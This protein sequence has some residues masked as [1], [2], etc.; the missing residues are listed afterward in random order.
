MASNVV[1][2]RPESQPQSEPRLRQHEQHV[3]TAAHGFIF[4]LS[5]AFNRKDLA[6]IKQLRKRI[7]LCVEAMTVVEAM[8][9]DFMDRVE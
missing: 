5:E 9:L 1:Q 3:Q 4:A 8:A 7:S 2:M 6:E